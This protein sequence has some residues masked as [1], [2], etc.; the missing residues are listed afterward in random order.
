MTVSS[1]LKRQKHKKIRLLKLPFFRIGDI[2]S[3]SYVSNAIT[4][5]FKGLC[6]AKKMKSFIDKQSSFK[7]RSVLYRVG[8]EINLSVFFVKFHY[9]DV[10]Y[11]EK[12][13]AF[14]KR[15]KL[16]YLR[17]KTNRSSLVKIYY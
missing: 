4:L 6:M 5:Y 12:K 13:R 8:V 2:I 11:Y 17:K 7:L 14:Y 16:Y 10:N 15:A 1:K 9:L 3:L